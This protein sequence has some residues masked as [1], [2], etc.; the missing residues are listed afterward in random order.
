MTEV[1]TISDTVY[2]TI[3]RGDA[4]VD[5]D[6]PTFDRGDISFDRDYTTFDRDCPTFD[7]GDTALVVAGW[8]SAV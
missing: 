2:I 6:Y 3:D 5:R 8:G 4:T 1:S 7:R